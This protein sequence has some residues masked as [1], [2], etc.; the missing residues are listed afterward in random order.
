MGYTSIVSNAD[1]GRIY[2]GGCPINVS[3]LLCRLGLAA[4]P[5]VRVGRDWEENGFRAFLEAGGVGLEGIGV[6]AEDTTSNCYLVEDE[7]GEHMTIFYPGAQD[8]RHFRP[9]DPGLFAGVE[10]GVMT[11]GSKED[12]LEFFRRVREAGIPLAF[13]MKADFDAFPAGV[14]EGF[15]RHSRII[16]TNETERAEIESRLGLASLAELL[17][18]EARVIVTTKGGKGSVLQELGPAGVITTEVPVSR[19]HAIVDTTGSGDAYMAGFIYGYLKGL[20]SA[21]CCALGST[22][23][24]FIIEAVGCCTNAPGEEALL[25]RLKERNE[26]A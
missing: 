24:A 2:Y 7:A 10:L 25:A 9:M 18:G 17:D 1:N 11:V 14:L 13:G 20:G 6:V 3:Y 12:N 8:P 21:D 22:L 15:L 26:K 19:P 5:I 16:F 4:L 23:A